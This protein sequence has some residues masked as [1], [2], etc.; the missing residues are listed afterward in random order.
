MTRRFLHCWQETP[1]FRKRVALISDAKSYNALVDLDGK[2]Q[3]LC[4]N[5][6]GNAL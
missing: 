2:Q 5:A 3:I 4:I 1:E 6:L